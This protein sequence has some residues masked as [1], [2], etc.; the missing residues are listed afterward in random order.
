MHSSGLAIRV[1]FV[2]T[3]VLAQFSCHTCAASDDELDIFDYHHSIGAADPSSSI[4]AHVI[5]QND[6]SYPS[7][8]IHGIPYLSE[9]PRSRFVEDPGL[10]SVGPAAVSARLSGANTDVPSSSRH[11]RRLHSSP[12]AGFQQPINVRLP[13][14]HEAPLPQEEYWHIFRSFRYKLDRLRLNPATL[15]LSQPL[16]DVQRIHLDLL[17]TQLQLQIDSKQAVFI[18]PTADHKARIIAIP[19]Q[20]E[21]FK[22]TIVELHPSQ[23]VAWAILSIKNHPQTVVTWL[24]YALLEV[25]D[26][27]TLE[28]V[29]KNGHR[30]RTLG[31]FLT[32]RPPT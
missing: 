14:L 27:E 22:N 32:Y 24:S 11:L 20:S 17:H 21:H 25:H 2:V 12:R 18:T 30:V 23:K 3:I 6:Q 10:P 28:D 16:K 7:T 29:L 19:I 15:K 31:N 1:F 9:S 5:A 4:Y 8:Q 13:V 26:R